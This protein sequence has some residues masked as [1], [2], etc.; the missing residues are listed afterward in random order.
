MADLKNHFLAQ[1]AEAAADL[2]ALQSFSPAELAA[3]P[4]YLAELAKKAL[5]EAIAANKKAEQ[6][7]AEALRAELIFYAESAAKLRA[8]QAAAAK[9]AE[10]AKALHF[11]IKRFFINQR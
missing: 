4:I 8:E 11:Y 5:F 10:A 6:L 3:E 7:N 2:A 9:A 1:A